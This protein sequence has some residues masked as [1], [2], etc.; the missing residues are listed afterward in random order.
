MSSSSSNSS[1]S[2]KP[3]QVES[4][5]TQVIVTARANIVVRQ[6][7]GSPRVIPL[8]RERL[9]IGRH[10]TNTVVIDIATVSAEHAIIENIDGAYRL[11]DRNSKNGT[12]VNG[13]RIGVTMLHDGDIIRIGDALSLI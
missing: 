3:S 5:G 10:P 2:N 1:V 9:T 7:D 4:T 8:T 11:T 6:A 12:F 13:E